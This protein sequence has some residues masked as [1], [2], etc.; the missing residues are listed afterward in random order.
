MPSLCKSGESTGMYAGKGV[1][2]V[3]CPGCDTAW[4][5]T[6][7]SGVER[8]CLAHERPCRPGRPDRGGTGAGKRCDAARSSVGVH[9]G[10]R[11]GAAET[12]APG[13][14]DRGA[15]CAPAGSS[16][17]TVFNNTAT[18]HDGLAAPYFG[19]GKT[20]SVIDAITRRADPAAGLPVLILTIPNNPI[21]HPVRLPGC[22][23]G[24]TQVRT[25]MCVHV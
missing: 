11:K 16:R 13:R 14:E 22:N 15:D 8:H 25:G 24:A 3:V 5:A 21:L 17:M 1:L 6:G 19:S 7:R 23:C 18:A 10:E 9:A 4:P 20:A 12:G 2:A